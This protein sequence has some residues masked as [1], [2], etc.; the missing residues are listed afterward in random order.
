[1][2]GRELAST[3]MLAH[4]QLWQ[5]LSLF[6]QNCVPT[7]ETNILKSFWVRFLALSGLAMPPKGDHGG[8]QIKFSHVVIS[9]D[10]FQIF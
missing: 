3:A 10:F 9:P 5:F 6:S 4:T 1:M 7:C 8:L 2:S